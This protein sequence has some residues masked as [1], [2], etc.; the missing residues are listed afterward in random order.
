MTADRLG[1]HNDEVLSELLSLSEAEISELY[2][3][4]VIVRD[5]SL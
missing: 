4:N 2:A 3:D 5:P 1:E